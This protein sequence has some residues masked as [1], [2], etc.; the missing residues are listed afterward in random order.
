MFNQPHLTLDDALGRHQERI[1]AAQRHR[2]V[3]QARRAKKERKTQATHQAQA[4]TVPSD[5]PIQSRRNAGLTHWLIRVGDIVA[6][7]PTA[8]LDGHRRPALGA[9]VD[10]LLNAARERGADVP[11]N[12]AGEDSAVVVLRTLS[13]L[14]VSTTGRS[15]PVSRRRARVL[16]TALDDLVNG[17]HVHVTQSRA[18]Q[19]T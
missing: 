14:G 18:D 2:L 19:A 12:T 13:R 7:Y 17:N 11:S 6:Q 16:Q 5:G 4:P 1:A 8:E 15:I 10:K 9:L 3:T